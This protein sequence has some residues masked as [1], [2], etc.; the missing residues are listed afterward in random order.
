VEPL[1]AGLAGRPPVPTRTVRGAAVHGRHG[2]TVLVP[3]AEI[4]GRAVVAAW[5][6][7]AMLR[8]LAGATG[9]LVVPPDGLADGEA[10]ESLPLPWAATGTPNG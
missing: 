6:G 1:L 5:R 2:S 9:I 4:D 8:G 7:A 3:Y 10:A